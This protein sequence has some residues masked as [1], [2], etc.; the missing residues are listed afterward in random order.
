MYQLSDMYEIVQVKTIGGDYH[1]KEKSNTKK[2]SQNN[3][4]AIKISFEKK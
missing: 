3:E 2:A 1:G 4:E